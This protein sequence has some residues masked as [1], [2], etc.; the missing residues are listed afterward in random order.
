M[1]AAWSHLIRFQ[2]GHNIYCGDAVFPEGTDPTDV[3]SIAKSGRLKARVIEGE[4]NPVSLEST[5]RLT[6]SVLPV[7]KL[8]SPLTR[9]QVPIIRCIGLNYVEHSTSPM[10]PKAWKTKR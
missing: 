5:A 6:D 2:N 3:V 4:D 9:D 8:L 10:C 7:Q 1:M